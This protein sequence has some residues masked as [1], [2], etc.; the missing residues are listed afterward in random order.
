MS[1]SDSPTDPVELR[2]LISTSCRPERH[3]QGSP[4]FIVIWLPLRVTPV[5]PRV[6]LSVMV[7]FV[8]IDAAVFPNVGEGRQLH[9]AFRGYFWVRISCDPQ[10]CS[11]PF[12]NLCQR[13]QCFRLPFA[14]PSSYVG[15]LPNSH[16]RTLTDKSYVLHSIPYNYCKTH[17]ILKR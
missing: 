15:E 5:T 1:K 12:R 14:P 13:T 16:S 8:R 3:R 10:I 2:S 17:R 7:V 9:C 4:V 6:H 11:A